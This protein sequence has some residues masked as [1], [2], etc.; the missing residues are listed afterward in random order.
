MR[1]V[2]MRV[3]P[4]AL[5]VAYA[6]LLL[7]DLE[8]FPAINPD[9]PGYAEPA[10]TLI[11]RG[12]F[13]APMYAGMFGMEHRIYTNWPGRGVTTVLPYLIIGPT[14]TAA[15]LV[16]VVMALLLAL[17]SGLALRRVLGR[18]LAWLDWLALVAVLT[19]PVVVVAGR[20][21]RPEIDVATWTMAMVLCIE[22]MSR[23]S[24]RRRR[25][26]WAIASGVCAGLAFMMHQY[27]L[28]SL[29]V[30]LLMASRL[31]GGWTKWRITDTG[32]MVAGTA[33]A[34]LPWIAFILSDV[35][36]FQ[37]QFEAAV[38]NQA[39]RYPRG[40]LAR[41]VINELPG[42]YML[43]RQDYPVDW[44][45]WSEATRLLVP[46]VSTS[47]SL[48]P[49]R[50]VVR[51]A[52][53]PFELNPNMR[54]RVWW[55]GLWVAA[56]GIATVETY[57][58]RAN[59]WWLLGP[60]IVWVIALSLVPNKWLGYAVTPTVLI[61]LGGYAAASARAGSVRASR[62]AIFAVATLTVVFNGTA[63]VDG[64][65][66]ALASRSEI[67]TALHNAIPAG[68]RV[69]IPFREW[70]A[71]VG[72]NPAI[73]LEGR[74]LPMFGTSLARSA[75]EFDVEYVVLVRSV[76]NPASLYWVDAGDQSIKRLMDSVSEAKS[77]STVLVGRSLG[78][79]G[80]VARLK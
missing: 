28:I 70:Y 24:F 49:L 68:A 37:L 42:R 58:R 52:R 9:E 72:R 62:L 64:W 4:V 11:T 31:W 69:M 10:W 65:R 80:I 71:F 39:W 61:G 12:E 5:L 27:G 54:D 14:L 73:G 35:P 56:T 33:L 43:D 50:L 18:S 8:R 22:A 78:E 1:V 3:L 75:A 32:W 45:P 41:T 67:V 7:F 40:A 55:L 16:S 17:L 21:A 57:R 6:V 23:E 63:I 48:W 53:R 66:S 38:A 77:G 60:G 25:R 76:A 2:G 36:E 34:L 15:R 79:E 13:G 51:F 74:S 46:A 20:F 30:G 44:D 59:G 29:G 47:E 26:G 19:S